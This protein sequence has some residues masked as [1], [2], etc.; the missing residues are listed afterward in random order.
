MKDF[1]EHL[2]GNGPL[3]FAFA[4][5]NHGGPFFEWGNFLQRLGVPHVLIRDS[6]DRWYSGGI[7]GLGDQKTV[8]RY[9]RLLALNHET[10]IALGLSKGAYASLK[11]GKLAP[12]SRI[13]A[14]SPVTGVGDTAYPDFAPHWHHRIV[15]SSEFN[16]E[17]LKPLYE[18]GPRPEIKIFIGDGDG[19]ELD[20]TMAERL[21]IRDITLVSGYDHGGQNSV[22]KAM[23]DNG[24]LEGL[25]RS[26]KM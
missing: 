25:I 16:I 5:E 12:V 20:R 9:M 17:D 4:S 23:R 21:G 19:T 2:E 8:A 7:A 1:E 3:V 22:A 14:M 6:S 13:I 18:N 26:W 15:P 10:S 24:M 11:F